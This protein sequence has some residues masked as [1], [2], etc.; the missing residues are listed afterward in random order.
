MPR[1]AIRS[2]TRRVAPRIAIRT[3]LHL[4]WRCQKDAR[5][6]Y[7][8]CRTDVV[9]RPNPTRRVHSIGTR[10]GHSPMALSGGARRVALALGLFV[11]LGGL[12]LATASD[13]ASTQ[14]RHPA[15]GFIT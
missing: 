6:L 11:V 10:P 12:T 3:R 7:D 4:R 14:D 1:S 9:P 5:N 8:R 15:S 13:S 2:R